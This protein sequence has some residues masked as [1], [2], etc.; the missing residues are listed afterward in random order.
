MPQEGDNSSY[1]RR[2]KNDKGN[3]SATNE[4]SEILAAFLRGIGIPC[5]ATSLV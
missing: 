3:R 1:D 5:L 2:G 4:E